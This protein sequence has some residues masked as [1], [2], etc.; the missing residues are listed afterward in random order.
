MSFKSQAKHNSQ[1]GAEQFAS[2]KCGTSMS[3][4]RLMPHKRIR[5]NPAFRAGPL[6]SIR[7]ASSM[8]PTRLLRP[9]ICKFHICCTRC[10]VPSVCCDPFAIAGPLGSS[11]SQV[12]HLTRVPIAPS[13]CCAPQLCKFHICC[14]R[15]IVSSV[16]CDPWICECLSSSTPDLRC[17]PFVANHPQAHCHQELCQK[18]V[19]QNRSKPSTD[20]NAL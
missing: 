10:I 19:A 9:Q 4:T 15:V 20:A 5:E 6:G 16:C 17:P 13:S 7:I 2:A 1:S 14:T 12:P 8:S 18:N 11:E 3:A